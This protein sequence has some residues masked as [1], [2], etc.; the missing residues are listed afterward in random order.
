MKHGLIA[1][2]VV[3]GLWGYALAQ[4][5]HKGHEKTAEKAQ[6]VCPMHPEVVS[7]QPGVCPICNMKL[8]KKTAESPAVIQDHKAH[9]GGSNSTEAQKTIYYCPMHPTYTSDRPGD[10]PICNMKLIERTG[11]PEVLTVRI[12]GQAD[13]VVS[14]ER[15]QL[16]GVRWGKVERRPLNKTL[17]TVGR[18]D[19]DEGKVSQVHLLIDGWIQHL[20]VDYTYQQVKKGQALFSVYSPD[21]VAS[22]EEY[23]LALRAQKQ[24][25]E[26]PFADVAAGA[27]ALLESAH[28]R[29]QLW[30][31]SDDQIKAL[32]L[33]G[34]P[35]TAL[36]IHAEHNGFVIEKQARAGMRVE[37]GMPLY[38][39]ADLSQVWVY[40]DIYEYELSRVQVGQVVQVKPT[41]LPGQII[42]GAVTYVNPVVDPQTRTGRVR[43]ELPNPNGQL[44]P[45][46]FAD[47]EILISKG[48]GLVV[49][50]SAVLDSGSRQIVFVN[51]GAGR[52]EPRQVKIGERFLDDYEVLEGLMEGETVVTS[53]NFLIDAESQI[54]AA[55]N[56]MS[57]G[58]QH[59]D[60]HD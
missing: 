30:G 60:R 22:Q 1:I 25:A 33:R 59:G 40:A 17:R 50:G 35:L 26:N 52:F 6:Y 34:T 19:Y 10:C 58:H 55:L 32:S 4:G 23:L 13:V 18:V 3:M 54:K 44:K 7:D 42:H 51:S 15:Q 2:Y 37:A 46:M 31:I 20:F 53:A 28:R 43:I 29:L 38:V 49:P 21:L 56:A 36:T 57:A 12:P 27:S 14:P 41:Y 8:E 9:G 11:A 39:I 45:G 24:F 5:D 47:V 16:I 48:T